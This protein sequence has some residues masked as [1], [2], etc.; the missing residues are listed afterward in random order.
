M[1]DELA[2]LKEQL[3]A[4]FKGRGPQAVTAPGLPPGMVLPSI[5]RPPPMRVERA[6]S[7]AAIGAPAPAR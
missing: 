7:G 5:A 1:R 4:A 3:A 2:K 6:G